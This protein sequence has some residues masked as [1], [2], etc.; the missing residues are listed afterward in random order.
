MHTPQ[1]LGLLSLLTLLLANGLAVWQFSVNGGVILEVLWIYWLQ[2]VVIGAVNVWRI[3]SAPL[4]LVSFQKTPLAAVAATRGPVTNKLA[5]VMAAVFFIVHYGMFHFVYAIFLIAFSVP[6]TEVGGLSGVTTT[7]ELF[8]GSINVGW[9]LLGGLVFAVHHILTF[10]I[11]RRQLKEHPEQAPTI[12]ETMGRPYSRI[13]P[14]HLI[15]IFGPWV[16]LSLGSSYVFVVFMVLKTL[17]DLGLFR[18]GSSHPGKISASRPLRT[19]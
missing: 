3:M 9:V 12:V 5:A 1:R 17:A 4:N 10:L 15:I 13:L 19:K 14:M 16:A 7:G 11:E 2:S 6:S 18:D 8:D